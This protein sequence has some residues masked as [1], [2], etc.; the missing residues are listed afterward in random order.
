MDEDRFRKGGSDALV[1]Q[2][3]GTETVSGSAFAWLVANSAA[4][5]V[6]REGTKVSFGQEE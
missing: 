4:I 1:R 6:V 2:M 3:D 5:K